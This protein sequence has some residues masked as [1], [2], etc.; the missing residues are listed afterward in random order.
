MKC[1]KCGSPLTDSDICMNCGAEVALYKKIVSYSNYYYNQGLLKAQVRDLTGAIECLKK[2]L[3]FNKRNT[4]ARNLLGLVYYEMG[5][6][7]QALSEWVISKNFRGKKN[8]AD[9]YLREIQENPARLDMVNQTIKKYNQALTYVQQNSEDLAVIQ[10]KKVLSMNPKL[11]KGYQLLALLQI[12]N[13]E[14]DKARKSL[15]K[16]LAIDA[17]NTIS[18]RYMNEIDQILS[19]GREDKSHKISEDSIAYNSDVIIPS[20]PYKEYPMGRTI[21]N[22]LVGVVIGAALLGLL[23]IPAREKMISANNNKTELE[24]SSQL[25]SKNEEISNL[26]NQLET[27]QQERDQA[28]SELENYTGDTGLIATYEHLFS[29]AR[30]FYID[31]DDVTAAEEL[32]K[33][34][35]TVITEETVKGIYDAIKTETNARAANELYTEGRN[36]YNRRNYEEA[37]DAFLRSYNLDTTNV[38]T[39]FY[40]ARA[41]QQSGDEENA[42]IYYQKVIDEFPDSSRAREAANRINQ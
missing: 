19:G 16:S 6:T 17:N 10:L 30:A 24:Y 3:K 2:S 32:A 13:E 8:L 41:Y 4:R 7:V 35:E 37:I 40:L 27:L 26:Q 14:Y 20:K 1:Y 31:E 29:A 9:D 42:T 39:I 38:D 12:K 21:I 22:I 11:I 33:I 15:K 23:I 25:S 5:E 36:A 34:D 28:V 18:M